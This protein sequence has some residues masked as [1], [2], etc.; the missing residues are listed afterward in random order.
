VR[1]SVQSKG[2]DLAKV[3]GAQVKALTQSQRAAGREVAK[4]GA[5]TIKSEARGRRGTLSFAGKSIGV[6][7]KTQARAT[8]ST[9]TF[10]AKPAGAWAIINDGSK[11]HP[12]APKAKGKVLRLGSETF[13][14]KVD[15]PGTSGTGVWDQ[16]EGALERALFDVVEDAA[17]EALL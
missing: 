11:P 1:V 17:D 10:D 7:T 6:R 16:T 8:G 3:I 4:V 5:K 2:P 15:H 9:V 14:S 12:I 13:Y